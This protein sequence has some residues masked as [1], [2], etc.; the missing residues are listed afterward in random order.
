MLVSPLV[1]ENS[2][3][4]K[5]SQDILSSLIQASSERVRTLP[6][7]DPCD[8]KRYARVKYTL[9]EMNK[10]KEAIRSTLETEQQAIRAV[11]DAVSKK[12]IDHIYM[13]GCG[14][15]LFSMLG[16]RS[17][18]ER[19]LEVPCEPM[20]ALDFAYYNSHLVK[21]KTMVITLSSSGKTPRTM[22]AQFVARKK[23][24]TTIAL[25]N[26]M[27]TPMM[28]EADHSLYIHAERKGW[29]TQSS[30]AAMAI[31]YQ[32][33]FEIVKQRDQ[34]IEWLSNLEAEFQATVDLI[35]PVLDDLEGLI[36]PIAK[37]EAA[38]DLFLF[39][40][41]GPAFTCASFGAAKTKELTSS[42]AIA[43]PLEEYHHYRSQKRGEPLFLV[44][45]QGYSTIRARDTGIKGL[46]NGG[47]VY[48]IVTKGDHTL[49]GCYTQRLDLPVI[50]ELFAPLLYTLPLQQFAYYLAM[51]K[52][53]LAGLVQEF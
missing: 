10:Q 44:A 48:A 12:D 17:F 22:E 11:A 15:S 7:D 5:R 35:N 29:P 13:V 30:T 27:G 8:E 37:K 38:N 6:S 14:D 24:A 20:Q 32:L 42:H 26:T 46:E 21:E 2:P 3:L 34:Q 31:L 1:G 52:F 18:L 47:H 28:E 25:T 16:V 9:E 50:N 43:I 41:G 39:A 19:I 36:A 45:P 40:G 33:G 49:D 53:R 23:G 4:D 51:E